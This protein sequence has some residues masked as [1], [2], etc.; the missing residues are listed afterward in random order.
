MITWEAL[1]RADLCWWR[2]CDLNGV[3]IEVV[4]E[5]EAPTIA[6]LCGVHAHV[7]RSRLVHGLDVELWHDPAGMPT[8]MPA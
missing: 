7:L 4:I 3:P 6:Y 5:Q 8:L 1:R 2:G